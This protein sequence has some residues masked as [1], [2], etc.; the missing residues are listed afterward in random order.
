MHF[1]GLTL[2]PFIRCEQIKPAWHMHIVTIM[3]KEISW[4]SSLGKTWHPVYKEKVWGKT[5]FHNIF[6]C[7]NFWITR[8]SVTDFFGCIY[9]QAPLVYLAFSTMS[10][11]DLTVKV[12]NSLVIVCTV[13]FNVKDLYI[14]SAKRIYRFF[15][16]VNKHW[17]FS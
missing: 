15:T 13:H 7:G 12:I 11:L 4:C 17:L 16:I 10:G 14:L 5:G 9:S 3:A 1:I 8:R 6:T 2:Q